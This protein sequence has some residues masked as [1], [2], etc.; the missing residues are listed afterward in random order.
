[1][2]RYADSTP[3]IPQIAAELGAAVV[4]EGAVQ[5][6][7]DQVRVNVQLID[8]ASDVHIW[9]E[10]YDRALTTETI[11]A[12]QAN[13]AQAVANA[14][15][16]ALSPEES[17]TL[18]A[19][20]TRNLEA[21]EAFLRGSLWSGIGSISMEN[22]KQAIATFDRAIALDPNFAEAYA[23]KVRTQ[24]LSFWLAVGP[25]SC[26]RPALPRTGIAS[27][28]PSNAARTRMATTVASSPGCRSGH[29]HWPLLTL[30]VVEGG[31]SEAIR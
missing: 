3:S 9:A 27:A 5:R 26:A 11:F 4:L 15:Q 30:L 16:V 14:M 31:Q 19:G 22:S 29:V 17:N 2:M 6:A 25:R 1:M 13:I 23:R 18:R 28:R 8:G 20:S 10:N 24:L 12:I 21:Y 7:G